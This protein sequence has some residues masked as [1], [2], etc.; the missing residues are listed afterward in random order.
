MKKFD[1]NIGKVILLSLDGNAFSFGTNSIAAYLRN[2]KYNVDIIHCVPEEETN[3]KGIAFQLLSKKQLQILLQHCGSALVVGIS[4]VTTHYLNCA[5]QVQNFL[6]EN[7]N[8]PIVWGGVP[9]ICDPEFYLKYSQFVCTGEGEIF[10]NEFLSRLVKGES[11]Y[12]VRGMAYRTLDGKIIYNPQ[13]PLVDVNNIPLPLFNLDDHYILRKHIVSLRQDPTSFIDSN[14]AKGYRIFPIRGCPFNCTYC[15]NNK[16]SKVLKGRSKKVRKLRSELVI[17]ELLSAKRMI[18]ELDKIM[19]YED[20]FFVRTEE[21]LGTLISYYK[22]KINLPISTNGTISNISENKIKII[23]NSKIGIEFIKIGLQTGSERI[24]KEIFRRPFNKKEY[25]NKIEMLCKRKVPV[26]LD[27]ISDNPY[28]NRTDKMESIKFLIELSKRLS[29]INASWKY[30]SYMD[31]KLMYYPGTDLYNRA[32]EDGTISKKYIKEVLLS[33]KTTRTKE[34]IDTEKI[35]IVLFRY[36][37]KYKFVL[38]LLK[39]IS[40]PLIYVRVPLDKILKRIPQRF[41]GT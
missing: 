17:N 16:L 11:I 22:E 32:I 31:H 35:I 5:I 18:P 33:R 21:E 24:N 10:M 19:F 29:K 4:I 1:R 41:L 30:L 23:Q 28:E 38:H 8:C 34:D 25:L 7:V 6:K 3:N 12:A 14:L 37:L 36:S 13:I 27:I 39:L 20:D 26:I 15:S 2:Q 9:V 40:C